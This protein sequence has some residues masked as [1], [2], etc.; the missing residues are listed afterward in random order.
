MERRIRSKN[1]AFRLAVVFI[2]FALFQG[3][4]LAMIMVGCGVLEQSKQN[5]YRI[6]SEKVNGRKNSLENEMNIWT[7]TEFDTERMSR[8]FEKTDPTKILEQKDTVLEELAP[9]L[10]E[11]LLR[12]KSTGAFIIL[13]EDGQTGNGAPALYFR[14]NNPDKTGKDNENLYM[15]AGPW[16][17]AEEMRIATTSNWTFRLN[18]T[19]DN[20]EFFNKPYEAAAEYG[21]SGWLGYWSKPFQVNPQD[22]NVIT[23]SIPLFDAENHVA[24]IC[25][26]EVSVNYLYR[27]LPG[28]DFRTADSYGYIIGTGSME[29]GLYLSITHGALQDRMLRAGEKLQLESMDEKNGIYR[30][31]NHNGNKDLCV[32]AGRMGMYYHNTPFEE[33]EWYLMGVMEEPDLLYFSKKIEKL[34]IYSL[35]S[36]TGIGFVIAIFVS[37]WFTRHAKLMELSGLP[38]GA[39]EIRPHSAG[40]FMTSQVPVLLRLTREQERAFTRSKVKFIAYLKELAGDDDKS[41]FKLG[42]QEDAG[43]IK[44]TQRSVNGTVRCVVED[45]TEEV[46]QTKALRV[47]RD[48]DGLTGVGNRL[49]FEKMIESFAEQFDGAKKP[50]FVMCDLNDLKLVND[51]YGHD[52]GDE[53]IRMAAGALQASFKDGNIFRIGGDEFAVFLKEANP[54]AVAGG[55]ENIRKSMKEYSITQNFTASVAAGY[56]FYIAGRDNHLRDVLSRADACMYRNKRRMKREEGF[57][58]NT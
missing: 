14:N 5:E 26:I 29:D 43:F 41:I 53:Y 40:V 22:E 28:K 18:L 8:Y 55:I 30:L 31:L 49:A 12:T 13:T 42:G 3:I 24:A 9:L 11:M 1:I 15:L 2:C 54:V 48:R 16:N 47:E 56:A 19:D 32:S 6:F 23:Y 25:G 52:K 20:S 58:K 45:V 33:E 7:N 57:N 17:V 35:I 34:L 46:L 50:G 51:M 36:S 21:P 27:F 10:I 44:I 38:L 37:L 4:L 39:F